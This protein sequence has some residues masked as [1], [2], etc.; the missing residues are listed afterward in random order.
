LSFSK[1]DISKSYNQEYSDIEF[2][3]K[4]ESLQDDIEPFDVS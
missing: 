4:A 3:L 2:N 1:K